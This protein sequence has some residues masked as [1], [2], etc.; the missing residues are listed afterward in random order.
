MMAS[1]KQIRFIWRSPQREPKW[2]TLSDQSKAF[3]ETRKQRTSKNLKRTTAKISKKKFLNEA[4]FST[5]TAGF[6]AAVR[7]RY[8]ADDFIKFMFSANELIS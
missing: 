2:V 1:K 5:E 3:L 6:Q 7:S 4:L 8:K